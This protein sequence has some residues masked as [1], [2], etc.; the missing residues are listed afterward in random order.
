MPFVGYVASAIRHPSGAPGLPLL[1]PLAVSCS[2]VQLQRDK[3]NRKVVPKVKPNLAHFVAP[4][5]HRR[6]CEV[7][8][9]SDHTDRSVTKDG[10]NS[11][12]PTHKNRTWDS[13]RFCSP[14]PAT[15]V[16]MLR[17]LPLGKT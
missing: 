1:G 2:S 9:N 4:R 11:T 5:D 6:R 8:T 16:R 3:E 17:P 10:D 14:L 13:L 15:S 7:A 12:D